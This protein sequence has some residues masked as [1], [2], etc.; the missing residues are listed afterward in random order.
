MMMCVG[1]GT[2]GKNPSMKSAIC[3]S[4]AKDVDLVFPPMTP[5]AIIH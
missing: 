4:A 5:D 1:S 3:L 2:K